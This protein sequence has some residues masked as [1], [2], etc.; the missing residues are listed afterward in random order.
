M[1]N[2]CALRCI[3]K[4][5]KEKQFHKSEYRRER[6]DEMNDSKNEFNADVKSKRAKATTLFCDFCFS[7]LLECTKCATFGF[8]EKEIHLCLI[9]FLSVRQRRTL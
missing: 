1:V 4:E 7:K 3:G 2:V 6:G 8:G 9:T 5:N